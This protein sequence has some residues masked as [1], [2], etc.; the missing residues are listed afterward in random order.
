[1]RE[2]GDQSETTAIGLALG[3]STQARLASSVDNDGEALAISARAVDV[4]KPLATAPNA[5]VAVRRAYGE[6]LNMHGFLQ[7]GA[8]D[9]EAAVATLEEARAA[10]AASTISR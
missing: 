2:Q 8:C 6:V 4:L 7:C 3:L 5:S 10:Y 9:S 1:M